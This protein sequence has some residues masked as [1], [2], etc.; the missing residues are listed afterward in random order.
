QEQ[1]T[2]VLL[3]IQGV[4]GTAVG[5]GTNGEAV[6]KIYTER[7]GIGGLPRSL[8]GIS[9]SVQVTSQIVAQHH[10]EG[11]GVGP[12]GGGNGGS[13]IDPK[14]R[15][16]RPVPIGVSSGSER[17]I[18]VN[19]QFFCTTGTLGARVSGI[20]GVH[21]LSNAHVY[22]Q[23]GSTTVDEFG[24]DEPAVAGDAILQPGRADVGC[25]LRLGDQIGT[26]Y[27]W[28]PILL[29]GSENTIDAAIALLDNNN[30]L[31]TATPSDGYGTPSSETASAILDQ[32]VQKYGRTTS[33]TLGTVAGINATVFVGYD[34]GTAKFVGQIIIEGSNGAFSN[35]GDSGSLIVT[36][37]GNK[38]V[39]LLFAGNS[40]ITV[41]NPIEL[42]LAR[43]NVT[44]DDDAPSDPPSAGFTLSADGYKVK[45][46]QKVTLTS[47]G[48]TTT[49]VDI[50]RDNGWIATI[51]N[52]VSYT[53]NINSRGGGTYEYKACE[54]GDPEI[55]TTT[56]TVIF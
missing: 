31:G 7:S 13:E 44:I 27:D 49:H 48:A 25:D 51:Q 4:V 38:P 29:D 35:S 53:D 32:T 46:L 33:L 2:D 43:F 6:V 3:G 21:A 37:D 19:N 54:L 28:Q 16:D 23:E 8:D 45:G 50:F 26:L 40:T 5:L 36:Q 14:S 11:H 56:E 34:N 24:L 52:D 39:A 41:G 15:F 47:S 22:A 10:K 55:C 20:S 9:V 18:K 30:N 1:H 12:P 17:L 42:V